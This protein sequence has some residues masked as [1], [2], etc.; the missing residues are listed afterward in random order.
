MVM[1]AR[2]RQSIWAKQCEVIKYFRA[3]EK[4]R[5]QRRRMLVEPLEPRFLLSADL[6]LA[7]TQEFYQ[8]P[9]LEVDAQALVTVQEVAVDIEE[10]APQQTAND[11]VFVDGK[12]SI[13][14]PIATIENA[15]PVALTG[16]DAALVL[17]KSIGTQVV[18]IDRGVEDIDSLL[19]DILP[20]SDSNIDVVIYEDEGPRWLN[21]ANQGATDPGDKNLPQDI[22]QTKFATSEQATPKQSNQAQ[23]N[24]RIDIYY[25]D[26]TED[27]VDRVSE[28]LSQYDNLSAVHLLSHGNRGQLTLGNST[29][30]TKRLQDSREQVASWGKSLRAGGDILLYGC[31]V[32][33]GDIGLEFIEQLSRITLAD[34]AASTDDTGG[35]EAGGDWV[36]EASTGVIETSALFT[37]AVNYE[38]ALTSDT[39]TDKIKAQQANTDLNLAGSTPIIAKFDQGN[40]FTVAAVSTKESIKALTLSSAA[41]E[42]TYKKNNATNSTD[43]DAG[44]GDDTFYIDSKINITGTLDG[45]VGFD[46]LSYENFNGV[47]KFDLV[48]GESSGIAGAGSFKNIESF[49]G[50]KKGDTF[51]TSGNDETLDGGKGND[52][53]SYQDKTAWGSDVITD[54]A[55]KADVLDFQELTTQL[56]VNVDATLNFET[57]YETGVVPPAAPDDS[58]NTLNLS[59][60]GINLPSDASTTSNSISFG[61]MLE[62]LT[63][64][65]IALASKDYSSNAVAIRAE[66]QAELDSVVVAQTTTGSNNF[67]VKFIAGQLIVESPNID[68]ELWAGTDINSGGNKAARYNLSIIKGLSI[69]QGEYKTEL[70]LKEIETDAAGLQQ[71]TITPISFTATYNQSTSSQRRAAWVKDIKNALNG[72]VSTSAPVGVIDSQ[73]VTSRLQELW[74]QDIKDEIFKDFNSSNGIS[75]SDFDVS[76]DGTTNTLKIYS[77]LYSAEENGI[78][79]NAAPANWNAPASVTNNLDNVSGIEVVRLGQ[80]ENIINVV[81]APTSDLK[82]QALGN[83]TVMLDLS[84]ITENVE[85]TVAAD[86]AVTVS[87]AGKTISASNVTEVVTGSGDDKVVFKANAK[88]S[89]LN[90]GSGNRTL[91][92]SDFGQAIDD[93]FAADDVTAPG[94]DALITN[95]GEQIIIGSKEAD[96]IAGSDAA[97]NFVGGAGNDVI[98]GGAGADTLAGDDG[99]DILIGGAGIDNLTGGSGNDSL[100]GGTENDK[101]VGGAGDDELA[102]DAGDD[103]ILGGAG[104]DTLKGGAGSDSLLGGAGD[105]NLTGGE[106]TDILD[107]GAGSDSYLF[108]NNWGTDTVSETTTDGKADTLDFSK[109]TASTLS[110]LSDGK[111]TVGTDGV[112]TGADGVSSWA[113]KQDVLKGTKVSSGKVLDQGNYT[114]ANKVKS[115]DLVNIEKIIASKASNVFLFGSNWG[116]KDQLFA[117]TLTN[118]PFGEPD[119][120]TAFKN[121]NQAIEIDTSNVTDL[122]LDFRAVDQELEF[123]F[124]DDGSLEISRVEDIEWLKRFLGDGIFSIAGD[125]LEWLQDKDKTKLGFEI[126]FNTITISNVNANT[127]IYGG[128]NINTFTPDENAQFNGII[129]GGTGVRPAGDIFTEL[130]ENNSSG[131][132]IPEATNVSDLLVKNVL[133][134]TERDGGTKAA[135]GTGLI[136]G[137][138]KDSLN[139]GFKLDNLTDID[140]IKFSPNGVNAIFGSNLGSASSETKV[141]LSG[142]VDSA[143]FTA[144][145]LLIKSFDIAG[146][147]DAND[148]ITIKGKFNSLFAVDQILTISAGSTFTIGNDSSG[149]ST[150]IS[151]TYDAANKQTVIYLAAGSDLSAVV[152]GTNKIEFASKITEI[153]FDP[154]TP[155]KIESLVTSNNILGVLAK[156]ETVFLRAVSNASTTSNPLTIDNVTNGKNRL[157]LGNNTITID[158]GLSIFEALYETAN[159]KTTTVTVK[160]NSVVA[161]T[162]NTNSSIEVG[163]QIKAKDDTKKQVYLDGEFND[164]FKKGQSYNLDSGVELKLTKDASYNKVTNITVLSVED[165]TATNISSKVLYTADID[166]VTSATGATN[167]SEL[168]FKNNLKQLFS[169]D[170]A[171]KIK[172]IGSS[173]DLVVKSSKVRLDAALNELNLGVSL[174][175]GGIGGDTYKFEG[176][177]WGLASIIETPDLYVSIGN[178][179]QRAGIPG[180]FDTLDFS[181]VDLDLTYDIYQV[182]SSNIDGLKDL[183]TFNKKSSDPVTLELGTNIVLVSAEA[184]FLT[185][186][187]GLDLSFDS[188]FGSSVPDYLPTAFPLLVANDIENIV[189]SGGTNTFRFRGDAFLQG[190]ITGEDVIFD[191]S[192]YDDNSDGIDGVE[193]IYGNANTNFKNANAS[194]FDTNAAKNTDYKGLDIELIPAVE[195]PVVGTIEGWGATFGYAEGVLGNRLA[196]LEQYIDLIFG[197]NNSVTTALE[198]LGTSGFTGVVDSSGDD[199]FVGTGGAET[200]QLGTGGFD[201]V[202]GG[203]DSPDAG[204]EDGDDTFDIISLENVD[205]K[206]V[207]DLAGGKVWKLND[208]VSFDALNFN[209]NVL[210]YNIANFTQIAAFVDIEGAKGGSNADLIIGTSGA[211]K[212]ELSTDDIG[213]VIIGNGGKDIIDFSDV[214]FYTTIDVVSKKDEINKIIAA[215]DQLT[216]TNI[217]V[218]NESL[219][220]IRFAGDNNKI[221]VYYGDAE[222]QGNDAWLKATKNLPVVGGVIGIFAGS[223][224]DV[225]NPSS[226]ATGNVLDNSLL[227]STDFTNLVTQAK[228]NWAAVLGQSVV[229]ESLSNLIFSQADLAGTLLAQTTENISGGIDIVLDSNAAGY[230]WNTALT[231]PAAGTV[232]LLTAL[233]HEMGH[234]MGIGHDNTALLGETIATG[235]RAIP[236]ADIYDVADQQNLQDG[237]NAFQNWVAGLGTRLND[238]FTVDDD[239]PFIGDYNFASLFG[240]DANFGDDLTQAVNDAISTQFSSLF[241]T[242]INTGDILNIA[243]ISSNLNSTFDKAFT[244]NLDLLTERSL[245][246]LDL[247]S[248]K[249]DGF[250]LDFGDLPITVTG[251]TELVVDVNL[252]L[253]FG[254]G[255]DDS[256]QFFV[257]TPTLSAALEIFADGINTGIS[258]FDLIGAQIEEGYVEIKTGMELA[259]NNVLSLADLKASNIDLASLNPS[260]GQLNSYD[261]NLP[262]ALTGVLEGLLDN[263]ISVTANSA[264]LG[265]ATFL[266]AAGNQTGLSPVQLLAS[267][268]AMLQINGFENLADFRNMSLADIL[269]GIK[270]ILKNWTDPTN[271]SSP[272]FQKIPGLDK[273]VNEILGGTLTSVYDIIVAAENLA[274]NNTFTDLAA[275]E[276]WLNTEIANMLEAALDAIYGQSGFYDFAEPDFF[277][278]SY[279]DSQFLA[280]LNMDMLFSDSLGFDLDLAAYLDELGLDSLGL[281]VDDLLNLTAEADLEVTAFAGLY[282]GVGVDL[283]AWSEAPASEISKADFNPKNFMYVDGGSGISLS[284]D[285]LTTTPLDAEVSIDLGALNIPGLDFLLDALPAIGFTINDGNIELALEAFL[286]LKEK[287]DGGVYYLNELNAS[288]FGAD[289]SATGIVDLPMFFLPGNLAIGGTED[290]INGDGVGDNSLFVEVNFDETGFTYEVAAPDFASTFSI[291]A[292][293]NDPATILAGLESMFDGL[294]SGI[295]GRF[296]NLIL[297][298]LGDALKDVPNFIDDIRDSLLSKK[299]DGLYT[300]GLGKI[301]QTEA[302]KPADERRSTIQLIQQAI[303]DTLGPGGL[304]IISVPEMVKNPY[305]GQMER[306][307][308]ADGKIKLKETIES[309][310]D[311]QLIL[312]GGNLQFNII[313]ANEVFETKTV[314]LD[315]GAS[316]PGF[317]LNSDAGLAISM[318]Y[319]FG[320][321]FGFGAD[322]FYVDTTGIS[323]TGAEFALDLD[324][325]LS[326]GIDANLFFFEAGLRDYTGTDADGNVFGSGDDDGLSGFNG[327]FDIDITDSS[328]D[329]KWVILGSDKDSVAIEATLSASVN[330]D[331]YANASLPAI[332]LGALGIGDLQLELPAIETVIRYDQVLAEATLGSDGIQFDI[333]GD[334]ELKFESVTIDAGDFITNVLGPL[335]DPINTII[336]PIKPLIDLL[337]EEISFLTT[338]G[339][340]DINTIQKM[341]EAIPDPRAKTI[342]TII[343]AV[344]ALSEIIGDLADFATAGKINLGDFEI[345]LAGGSSSSSAGTGSGSGSTT[346]K[347]ATAKQTKEDNSQ[348]TI[349]AKQKR[350]NLKNKKSIKDAGDFQLTLLE[351]PFSAVG[352]LLGQDDVTIFKYVFPDVNFNLDFGQTVPVFPGLNAGLFGEFS[353]NTDISIGFDSRGL[354]QFL[355]EDFADPLVLFNGFFLEDNFVN[356]VDMPELTFGA[357]IGARAS[358]GIG[359]LVEAGVEGG[360]SGELNFDFNDVIDDGKFYADEFLSRIIDPKCLFDINGSVSAFLDAFF[361]VGVDL[362]LFGKA[363]LYEYRKSFVN[364]VLASFN[365]SCPPPETFDIA[366]LSNGNLNLRYLESNNQVNTT[367]GRNYSVEV[368]DEVNLGALWQYGAELAPDSSRD[369]VNELLFKDINGRDLRNLSGPQVIVKAGG[370]VEVFDADQVSSISGTGSS[371]KDSFVFRSNIFDY[372]NNIDI[373]AAGG[374]DTINLINAT[375]NKIANITLRGGS[376]NDTILGSQYADTIFAGTG[377]DIVYAN[378][379]DDTL[380][381]VELNS[382]NNGAA[383]ADRLVGGAGN[384]TIRSGSGNDI[385]YGDFENQDDKDK[386]LS[387]S[388]G[389]DTII[390]GAGNDTVIAGGGA[391][392]VWANSGNDTIL[393]GDGNDILRGGIGNDTIYGQAG[394]DTIYAVTENS[395]AN[396]V[397]TRSSDSLFGNAGDDTIYGADGNDLIS[398]G[399]TLSIGDILFGGDGNDTFDWQIG[400]GI[401]LINGGRVG[402]TGISNSFNDKLVA[403]GYR[404][405]GSGNTLDEGSLDTVTLSG[406]GDD[407]RID[408]QSSLSDTTTLDLIGLRALSIDTGDG[409]DKLRFN[410]LRNTTLANANNNGTVIPAVTV[411]LGSK[412]S[413]VSQEKDARDENGN[414]TGSKSTFNTL[415]KLDDNQSDSIEILGEGG[416]DEFILTSK[417][418]LDPETGNNAKVLDVAQTGGVT[419][420][421]QEVSFNKDQ[422]IIDTGA[423]DDTIDA[424]AVA[425]DVFN[426]LRL[427]GGAGDDR[428]I[429]TKFSELIIGGSGADRITGGT[430]V[431]VF[432]SEEYASDITREYDASGKVIIDTLIEQRDA[433]FTVSDT[434]LTIANSS[435]S[436]NED[437]NNVFEAFE[438]TGGDSVNTFKLTNWSGNGFMNGLDGSDAYIVNLSQSAEGANFI[439]INDTG[440]D[441]KD[442]LNYFGSTEADL[443]QL[444]TVYQQTKDPERQFKNDRW[445][446]YGSYGRR[447]DGAIGG[448]GL[449]IAHFGAALA[450]Y[451]AKDIDDTDALFEIGVSSLLASTNFQV[452]N[453]STVED[454]TVYGSGGDDVFISDD[455]EATLNLYGNE[456]DDQFYIGSILEVEDVLV[457]GQEITVAIEVTQGT[458]YEMNIFGG[459]DDDYFEVSHN[460]ADINL[461]GDNGDDTFFIKALLTL[462]ED[463]N[464]FDLVGKGTNVNAGKL[465]QSDNDT[466]EVD[467][468]SLVYVENANVNIDGGAGFD[469]VAVVGTALSDTFYIWAEE[470]ANGDVAQRIFGAGIKLNQLINIERLVLLT[471]AGDDRVYINGVDLG[472]NSDMV[473]NLGSGSDEVYIGSDSFEFSL[474]FPK[475]NAIEFSTLTGYERGQSYNTWG[476]TI[477]DVATKELIVPYTIRKPATTEK[478]LLP[479]MRSVDSIK[480]PLTI[481]GGLG[482]VDKLIINNENGPQSLEFSNTILLKKQI[483]TNDTVISFPTTSVVTNSLTDLLNQSVA[484]NTPQVK[485]ILSDFLRNQV[486]FEDKYRDT[487]LIKDLQVMPDGS[488]RDLTLAKD[489]SYAV[490]QDTLVPDPTPDAPD[491]KK[492]FTA[493]DQLAA[494]LAGTGYSASYKSYTVPGSEGQEIYYELTSISNIAGEQLAFESQNKTLTIDDLPRRNMIGVSLITASESIFTIGAG[495]IESVELA[496]KTPTALNTLSIENQSNNIFFEGFDEFDLSLN[497]NAE[498]TLL[499]DN[500]LFDGIM[501]VEGGELNDAFSVYA[502]NAQTFLNGNGGND[503]YSIGNGTVDAITAELFLIGGAGDDSVVVN[504]EALNTNANVLLE[505]TY[506]ENKYTQTKLNRI[507]S[508][509]GV[510]D[511]NSTGISLTE[512]EL[513]IEKLR[514]LTAS[515]IQLLGA[516]NFAQFEL[517]VK[518]AAQSYASDLRVLFANAEVTFEDDI[519]RLV[520][521]TVN[522]YLDGVDID[523]T[524]YQT[525]VTRQSSLEA[526][527]IYREKLETLAAN[528]LTASSAKDSAGV[529]LD[530]SLIAEYGTNYTSIATD[531]DTLLADYLAADTLRGDL[532]QNKIDGFNTELTT[533]IDTYTAASQAVSD[534]LTEFSAE[535]A[536]FTEI[537]NSMQTVL[538]AY[539]SD[540]LA[541]DNQIGSL[542]SYLTTAVSDDINAQLALYFT[543]T[544]GTVSASS[545]KDLASVQTAL[546]NQQTGFEDQLTILADDYKAATDAAALDTALQAVND[547]LATLGS[548]L[549]TAVSDDVKAQLDLYRANTDGTITVDSVINVAS[550]QNAL[551]AKKLAFENNTTSLVSSY[552]LSNTALVDLEQTYATSSVGGTSLQEIIIN[553]EA[554]VTTLESD[555]STTK[556]ELDNRLNE[557]FAALYT[558]TI[559]TGFETALADYVTGT[560]TITTLLDTLNSAYAAQAAAYDSTLVDLLNTYQQTSDALTRVELLVS[561]DALT[562]NQVQAELQMVSMTDTELEQWL[563]DVRDNKLAEQQAQSNLATQDT[564]IVETQ[565]DLVSYISTELGVTKQWSDYQAIVSQANKTADVI[566]TELMIQ[567]DADNA[568]E[569]AELT[570]QGSRDNFENNVFGLVSSYKAAVDSRSGIVE[571]IAAYAT[572][573]SEVSTLV[574]TVIADIENIK[575]SLLSKNN[576]DVDDYLSSGQSL[577]DYLGNDNIG[578]VNSAVESVANLIRPWLKTIMDGIEKLDY[579]NQL[580]RL[581]ENYKLAVGVDASDTALQAIKDHLAILNLSVTEQDDLLAQLELYRADTLGNVSQASLLSIVQ[582][583]INNSGFSVMDIASLN[584]AIQ[585]FSDFVNNI[586]ATISAEHDIIKSFA[587]ALMPALDLQSIQNNLNDMQ[588]VLSYQDNNAAVFDIADKVNNTSSFS[589]VQALYIDTVPGDRDKLLNLIVAYKDAQTLAKLFGLAKAQELSTLRDTLESMQRLNVYANFLPISGTLD[590]Q[591]IFNDYN[592]NLKAYDDIANDPSRLDAIKTKAKADALLASL[593][594]DKIEVDLVIQDNRAFEVYYSKLTSY[595]YWFRYWVKYLLADSKAVTD[596]ARTQQ[597]K[598]NSEIIT[599]RAARDTAADLLKT[600]DDSLE[601]INKDLVD[602]YQ[603]IKALGPVILDVLSATRSGNELKDLLDADSSLIATIQ[604]YSN[605]YAVVQERGDNVND[606]PTFEGQGFSTVTSR[607]NSVN[608]DTSLLAL[609]GLNSKGI[610]SDYDSIEQFTLNT[611]VGDDIVDVYD[612]LG[613]ANSI[614]QINS[615]DGDDSIRV[616][617]EL[618]T[619]DGVVASVLIDA[620][621]G[622]NALAIDDSDDQTDNGDTVLQQ[623]ADDGYLLLTGM[624]DGNI[625]YKAEQGDFSKGLSIATS[626]GDD[627]VTIAALFGSDLTEVFGSEGDDVIR[628]IDFLVDPAARLTLYGDEGNDLIDATLS[629]LAVTVY[630]RDDNDTILGSR[631]DDL[632]YGD[633]GNDTINGNDGNDTLYGGSGNDDLTGNDGDDSLYG[634]A[635]NDALIGSAGKDSLFGGAGDDVLLGDY[636]L[637]ERNNG[638]FISAQVVRE[639]EGDDDQLFGGDGDDLLIGGVGED[640][641]F[642]NAGSDVMFGDSGRMYFLPTGQQVFES[643]FLFS[644]ADD[645]LNGGSESDYMFGGF[646]NDT[647]VGSLADDAIFGEYGRVTLTNK[648]GEFVLRLGQGNLDVITSTMFGLYLPQALSAQVFNVGGLLSGIGGIIPTL[649]GGNIASANAAPA[650]HDDTQS[651]SA[652]DTF[653]DILVQDPPAAPPVATTPVEPPV[654][655]SL[656][657]DIPVDVL[658]VQPPQNSTENDCTVEKGKR[659]NVGDVWSKLWAEEGYD[660]FV[661]NIDELI[662]VIRGKEITLPDV[663]KC[664]EPQSK[665]D[666]QNNDKLLGAV[667]AGM[668][669]WQVSK[670]NSKKPE[671]DK[672]ISLFAMLREKSKKSRFIRWNQHATATIL[673][674]LQN[675]VIRNT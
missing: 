193:V 226:T 291:A 142:N 69:P 212:F 354:A 547:Q 312:D 119:F 484:D 307:F 412:R 400:D 615:G 654:D 411:S 414:L 361:W 145:D 497:I 436:E 447:T 214:A 650:S 420:R 367:E 10:I 548:S 3:S 627:D 247:K 305:T 655:D 286:G 57:T 462:D 13:V 416:V 560:V 658:P 263:G 40:R 465:D 281:N 328:A 613:Q 391:D 35:T 146:V 201:L 459:D 508:L 592:A 32:A 304:N 1:L 625:L 616:G 366:S 94:I 525:L 472:P 141:S 325:G 576:I 449:L 512:N 582:S 23:T 466:R 526:L 149:N 271:T 299:V 349:D 240:L 88:L 660:K 429:G 651:A 623:Y 109:V 457:E 355:D 254:F 114:F 123:E 551:A 136:P 6:P 234:A 99:D 440:T 517:S 336:E 20:A 180:F 169:A 572:T 27:G 489:I 64:K 124:K 84:A 62:G 567:I 407:V 631:F 276:D 347:K 461:Y 458:S 260:W 606:D 2:L 430:G 619:V 565:N 60:T 384:D 320:L 452:L 383:T 104:K 491:A 36:L 573:S 143:V 444:D 604:S 131:L 251:A 656:V 546:A 568:T 433:N 195:I 37:D 402:Q 490:F 564:F 116:L 296:D 278:F 156:G 198:F 595:Y 378:D 30:S 186:T 106:G 670:S 50:G 181:D 356:G 463:G 8:D 280:A 401:D 222:I 557:I 530:N 53:F 633:G 510:G 473:V 634:E 204:A 158:G 235:V 549:T 152:A 185:D 274:K 471:G 324:V 252:G 666:M 504:S 210:D 264:G 117:S 44:V 345:D 81:A 438:F 243:G 29:L 170:T 580:L 166:A 120:I 189:G 620:G 427:L 15:T 664:V 154:T 464:T 450:G 105:D 118:L 121:R 301:L 514:Q 404:R 71:E 351:D 532:R 163:L 601:A 268:P 629:P 362:G 24:Q 563:E 87:F 218:N 419:F 612:S 70:V 417:L 673:S 311:I 110:I 442:S 418:Q 519:A 340:T 455:T 293:L 242:N 381:G 9:L 66:L 599:Q 558:V 665:S 502:N 344:I 231:D 100:A 499:V 19:K 317:D 306:V 203:G 553:L 220:L 192:L 261:I 41:D 255:L 102:G 518:L 202:D 585:D 621:K 215:N 318:D 289:Y 630:G 61:L 618:N 339:A 671:E 371:T 273:N 103:E 194:Y 610:Y 588:A 392:E 395:S 646:G 65:T 635:G 523:V 675:N 628:V 468:D 297:P 183:L 652:T 485:E 413:I 5:W 148:S 91:D 113:S 34:V 331:L 239:I 329:G 314:G 26:T 322:G 78:W 481:I 409:A 79:T 150:K 228:D 456:G 380:Y 454:V 598:L 199:I 369:D 43:V 315:F 387:K 277:N 171:I 207:I 205:F 11:D 39:V 246:A 649:F 162:Y 581:A 437:L 187:L 394:N 211:D 85:V 213:D 570:A 17:S 609:T 448:D 256:G 58:G 639:T 49:V 217:D 486:L 659:L 537:I 645:F 266:D 614:V 495:Y 431:D 608:Y 72:V 379:G 428:L 284:A 144:G 167:V 288:A 334:P 316:L 672:D 335:L 524:L 554:Q 197:S 343:K 56:L 506:L 160:T 521:D 636:G 377:S 511:T 579:E 300:A 488:T 661:D 74:L 587:L 389:I 415:K 559:D 422:L 111:L 269:A 101:L 540:K 348:Q 76:I 46:T 403:Q 342:S 583:A 653:A 285:L 364:E 128:R 596:G 25:I 443:I 259:Y 571:E 33:D 352:L 139:F 188:L 127:V 332:D 578:G 223:S 575:A 667:A 21:K 47:V 236:E 538:D 373:N 555:E 479:E 410:D 157:S 536:S 333:G 605:E 529:N 637:I 439:N 86:G 227:A 528:V 245:L 232:D 327:S 83:A 249:L 244:A 45:Q 55:G 663:K 600:T 22:S 498:N 425:I 475:Q 543:N 279:E 662:D 357:T 108:E 89:L 476:R 178:D 360:V 176:G 374:D 313:I 294:K 482:K 500:S 496:D 622:S 505:K 591:T 96:N 216:A 594:K 248:L 52:I 632:L 550:L 63:P 258:L 290:D 219:R 177:F 208:A 165:A 617:S 350:D 262:I 611:G 643:D 287:A 607:V 603:I 365:Y 138:L 474:N 405:D 388:D 337:T 539:N 134:L 382:N 590:I 385:I 159:S 298:L 542:G 173:D 303:F 221:I 182:S 535:G 292:L 469:S 42:L 376:G 224:V 129:K 93:T 7:P 229:D 470:L 527:A 531:I 77:Y 353:V 115:S 556:T 408:W 122:V 487:N 513:I 492:I 544:D 295:S 577:R 250:G 161:A 477:Y 125:V 624:A 435:L 515:D 386:S 184:A 493:R 90:L 602:Q 589:E 574:Q 640:T 467:I 323:D 206:S 501:T 18:I 75:F 520:E 67:K 441:G 507:N 358:V 309:A 648:V 390:A 533:L 586:D 446:D 153:T 283:S 175:S 657:Q 359:G 172:T 398:G 534:L 668:L 545:I 478:R 267:L 38:Y 674:S 147:D 368:V 509:I 4:K 253:D 552:K 140:D 516:A 16:M 330:L 424:S 112:G 95:G 483:Q 82:F 98:T 51:S 647:F 126:K 562:L 593:Q 584:T 238:F 522:A 132:S 396:N 14:E 363:T 641:L 270:D 302:L 233:M 644:G 191:Y 196:G 399:S 168:K 503:D 80:A 133:D 209:N 257:E 372:I 225:V 12:K 241:G 494:F 59:L 341:I 326:G 569:L 272:L 282:L 164:L 480:S 130:L 541:F 92:Y 566:V 370:V 28:I 397:A 48:K 107:G 54:S 190:T 460:A 561:K 406:L 669:G 451:T 453:Y 73:E 432:Q 319:V 338:V 174:I 445:L 137:T 626:E 423:G 642:G 237:M 68:I 97:D 179:G 155:A 265:A 321:G 275:A 426:D 200:F 421:I 135:I 434:K 375:G 31:D 151:S 310:D 597:A 393:G 308:E 346:P 638:Q 230:G